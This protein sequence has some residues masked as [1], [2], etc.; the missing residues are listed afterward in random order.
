MPRRKR[1]RNIQGPP[2][3]DGFKPRG[4]PSRFLE[5]VV[6]T[7]D[8][9]ESIRL[10]DHE[11]LEH[12]AASERMG[13]SRSV[14]T[15][16][17]DDARKKVAKAIVEGCELLIEGGEYHFAHKTFRCQD[18]FHVFGIDIAN[19]DPEQCP[20]CGS[21]NIDNR[22]RQFGMRGQC[23]RHGGNYST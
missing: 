21:H 19:P 18:C 22:N 7:L 16:M 2:A 3:C 14:F 4:I 1:C 9:Y 15:R 8:E 23:R 13:I 6:L 10:A 5:T 11:N 12:E 20:E 17:L